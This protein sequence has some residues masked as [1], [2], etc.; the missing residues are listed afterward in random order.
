MDHWLSHRMK[1]IIA[2]L[3]LYLIWGSTYLA[4]RWGVESIPPFFMAGSRHLV[5]GLFLFFI[6]RKRDKSEITKIHW[7]SAFIIG[8]LL[9]L[10]GNGGVTWAEQHVP[11]GL[12]AL[13]VATVPL[14]IMILSWLQKENVRPG[15][16]EFIGIIL[17]LF[18]LAILV[19]PEELAGGERID[20]IGA[21][22]LLIASLAWSFGSLY[23]RKA[24][25]PSSAFLNTSMQ[26]IGGGV[27][28]I[29]LGFVT[30]ESGRLNVSEI[31]ARSFFSLVYLAAFGSL[32]GFSAYIW[33]LKVSTP[34][35]VTTYAYVNPV[36]AVIFGW[37]L[38][39]EELSMRTILASVVIIGSVVIITLP[40]NL[41]GWRKPF[42]VSKTPIE[43]T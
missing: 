27:L 19:G 2:F 30:G 38:A 14:W 22:A 43:P 42:F 31:T 26:M 28:L 34:A 16:R 39:G 11:S 21:I 40:K 37:L 12:A 3:A 41:N 6:I 8:G 9:L 36:V 23:S 1:I 32:I 4:I 35:K 10:G 20:P 13:L 25:V 18:G 17:G 24:P 33:L 29:I 5:A 7:R 15:I